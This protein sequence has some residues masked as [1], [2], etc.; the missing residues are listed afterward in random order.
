[1]VLIWYCDVVFTCDLFISDAIS[2]WFGIVSCGLM[3]LLVL[4]IFDCIWYFMFDLC[5]CFGCIVCCLLGLR[6]GVFVC[7][8][9][10]WIVCWVF[11]F[12]SFWLLVSL[13][14]FRIIYVVMY[15]AFFCF[16]LFN[17]VAII[18]VFIWYALVE[19]ICCGCD[20]F[21]WCYGFGGICL[22]VRLVV[23][24]CG[25]GV[26]IC[27]WL[28]FVCFVCFGFLLIVLYV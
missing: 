24:C 4:L 11:W 20:L 16:V 25:C 7:S 5:D 26:W 22:L 9:D 13:Y 3:F 23:G 6:F 14:G 2:V 1:M 18:L 10:C 27:L 15:F 21:V 8:V 17:S 19:L 28:L 12:W